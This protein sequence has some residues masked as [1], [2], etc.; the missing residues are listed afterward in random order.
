MNSRFPEFIFV[1]GVIGS[2]WT[3]LIENIQESGMFNITDR[4]PD[5]QFVHHGRYRHLGVFFGRDQEY[6]ANLD[7]NNLV[8][9]FRDKSGCKIVKSH[10][11]AF[12]LPEIKQRYP[13]CWI[14]LIYRPNDIALAWWNKAGGADIKH[15]VYGA[16]YK[17]FY[18]CQNEVAKQNEAIMEFAYSNNAVWYHNVPQFY[19]DCFNYEVNLE[20]IAQNSSVLTSLIK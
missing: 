3:S 8:A 4:N 14:W 2:M 15:P 12:I 10:E 17:N 7:Y 18:D 5:R 20:S 19:K 6:K 1:T 9:P 16:G 11:W 13:S